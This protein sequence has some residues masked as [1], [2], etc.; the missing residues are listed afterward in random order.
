MSQ[1]S[2]LATSIFTQQIILL[3]KMYHE[4]V[5]IIQQN[6]VVFVSVCVCNIKPGIFSTIKLYTKRDNEYDMANIK[7]K[8][9]IVMIKSTAKEKSNKDK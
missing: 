9:R 2:K 7:A 6:L 5:D 4:K 8:G 3:L 1:F